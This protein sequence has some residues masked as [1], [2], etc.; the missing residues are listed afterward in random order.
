MGTDA[1]LAPRTH[2]DPAA[3]VDPASH[4]EP[5]PDVE[6]A[7][8]IDPDRLQAF[9]ER[10]A[11]DQAASLHAATVLIGDRLG[12]YRSLADGGPQTAEA[13]ADATECDPRLV[14][15][16]LGAQV[17]S[18]YAA[19]D[20]T[21]GTYWLT[22]EQ[23]ACLADP[24]SPTFVAGAGLVI[25]SAHKDTEVVEAAFTGR[26]GVGWD[27]HHAHLFEGTRRFFEPVYRGNLLDSWIPALD[28]VADKLAAGA[29]VADVGCGH[30]AALRL[31]ADA[32]P[33][34]TFVGYDSHAGSI[35]AARAAA[36]DAGVADR[37][38][39]EVAGADDF[40]GDGFDLVCVFNALHELGEPVGAARRIRESLAPDGTWMFTEPIAHE[41]P[42]EH[43]RDRT[44]YS[45]STMVCTP[46]AIAQ[47]AGEAA[48]GAQAG[49]PALRR[50]VAEAGFTRLRRATETPSFMVLE[51]RP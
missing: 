4:A 15:E 43:V 32:Y 45:V 44:F 3:D 19:H 37:L 38:A 39:F 13:L 20:P 23:A 46:S 29:R 7:P 2:V 22:A 51:A 36:A 33:A 1:N 6:P 5:G 16:W 27:G 40:D 25:N 41:H 24:S 18:G 31:L 50:V 21:Q 17:A 26:G 35:E 34:S 9:L 47:G 49:E 14:R 12:L 42:I 11:A 10:F 30:G 48:L 28:G 8:D